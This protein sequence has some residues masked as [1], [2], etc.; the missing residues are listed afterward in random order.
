MKFLRSIYMSCELPSISLT[1]V[2]MS[3]SLS[4][5]IFC[6]AVSFF[7]WVSGDPSSSSTIPYLLAFALRY[8]LYSIRFFYEA[9]IPSSFLLPLRR[10]LKSAILGTI[11]LCLFRSSHVMN[12]SLLWYSLMYL[13]ESLN[14]VWGR[15]CRRY[16]SMRSRLCS[17]SLSRV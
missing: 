16:F 14:W 6:S 3:S 13:R 10:T 12:F 11:F 2:W 15:G 1:S 5:I 7:F 4:W 17:I 8:F 9:L